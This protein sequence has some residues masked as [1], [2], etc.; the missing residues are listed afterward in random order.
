MAVRRFLDVV[1]RQYKCYVTAVLIIVNAVVF[2]CMWINCQLPVEIPGRDMIEW[3]AMYSG[4][5]E[6]KEY[7]RLFTAMFLHFDLKHL[8]NNML[9]LAAIGSTTECYI[10]SVAYGFVYI[11]GGLGGNIVS[12]YMHAQEGANVVAAGASGAVYAAIGGLL[13]LLV[14]HKGRLE[15]FTI[16]RLIL[17]IILVLYQGAS[18]SGVDNYAHVGGLICGFATAFVCCLLKRAKKR[19]DSYSGGGSAGGG[20]YGYDGRGGYYDGR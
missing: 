10:G 5:L 1:F 7:Y 8:G 12:A 3:G 15:N 16:N 19:P 17:F 18:E 9:V 6:K 13:C 2:G 4:C 11:L 14:F 20:F